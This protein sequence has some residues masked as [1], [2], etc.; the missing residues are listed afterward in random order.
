MHGPSY[1]LYKQYVRASYIY[2]YRIM[3]LVYV[4]KA[5]RFHI[6]SSTYLQYIRSSR[7]VRASD[8]QCRNCPGFGSSILRPSGIRGAADEAV[9]N[10]VCTYTSFRCTLH[11]AQGNKQNNTAIFTRC[12]CSF[13]SC[14]AQHACLRLFPAN[15]K[16]CLRK[17]ILDVKGRGLE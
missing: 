17:P 15:H 16:Y 4:L 1:G 2:M 14:N 6:H 13:H 8:S 3:H 12:Y 5:C 10:I 7:V 11:A 9:L